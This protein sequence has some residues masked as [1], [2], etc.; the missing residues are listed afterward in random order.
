MKKIAVILVLI[1]TITTS[2]YA[3]N[4]I[5]A[6]LCKKVVLRVTG[7]TILVNRFTEEV[8]YILLQNGQWQLLTGVLK[9]QCQVIYNVQASA[10]K[11]ASDS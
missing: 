9:N 8:K 5:D 11:Q 2:A 3:L 4:P 10:N 1:L 6:I 7:S